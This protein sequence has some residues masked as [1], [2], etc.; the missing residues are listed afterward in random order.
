VSFDA[1]RGRGRENEDGNEGAY[2]FHGV[3]N[4]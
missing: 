2:E 3:L 1:E 4:A